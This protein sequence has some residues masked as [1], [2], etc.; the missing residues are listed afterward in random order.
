MIPEDRSIQD[1]TEPI[2]ENPAQTGNEEAS[3]RLPGLTRPQSPPLCFLSILQYR[4]Y[5]RQAPNSAF[6]IFFQL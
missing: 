5:L 4:N 3:T 6:H 2:A 1:V